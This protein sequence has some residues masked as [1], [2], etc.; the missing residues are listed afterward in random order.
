MEAK[1]TLGE[2]EDELFGSIGLAVASV[3]EA[4]RIGKFDPVGDQ[5]ELVYENENWEHLKSKYEKHK[6]AV[7]SAVAGSIDICWKLCQLN[8]SEVAEAAKEKTKTIWAD[9]GRYAVNVATINKHEFKCTGDK[10]PIFEDD[11]DD[12]CFYYIVGAIIFVVV[13]VILVASCMYKRN[14]DDYDEESDS[15]SDKPNP[16]VARDSD[17]EGASDDSDDSSSSDESLESLHSDGGEGGDE[18][19]EEGPSSEV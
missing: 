15:D 4:T 9:L 13:L 12:S 3:L 6:D 10:K 16:N 17:S 1:L 8:K 19:G 7:V 14:Q 2:A 18:S 5:L 11:E